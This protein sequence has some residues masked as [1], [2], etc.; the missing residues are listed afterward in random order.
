M[1]P[2]QKKVRVR[3]GIHK[4]WKEGWGTVYFNAYYENK[5]RIKDIDTLRASFP[6][7]IGS[8]SADAYS[9]ALISSFV[10]WTATNISVF[11]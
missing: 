3:V 10:G 9:P 4:E 8:F 6:H 11:P 5:E 2:I 7:A 1:H